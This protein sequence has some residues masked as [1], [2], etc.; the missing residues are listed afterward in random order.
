MKPN[1]IFHAMTQ[2][3]AEQIMG[4]IAE[5]SPEA[6]KQVVASA[7]ITL[8][9]RPQ[10]LFKQP[11]PKRVASVRRALSRVQSTPL[12][13]QMLAIYFL[14]CRLGLLTEWL[15][16]LGL[17]HEEGI[18]QDDVLESPDA[19]ALEKH[20]TTFRAGSDREDRELLLQ[21]FSA[22]AAIDWPALDALVE[23]D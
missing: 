5:A 4:K 6:F 15:D 1:Q 11:L 20:V 3:R 7:A 23:A 14:E 17:A 9:Y 13:E 19:N 8:K 16:L 22:Q 2:E 18:L 21:T 12:A 10:Y